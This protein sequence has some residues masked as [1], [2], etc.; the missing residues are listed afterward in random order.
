MHR[1]G[2]PLYGYWAYP[3]SYDDANG[4]GLL[5]LSEVQLGDTLEFQGS[6]HPSRQ[7]TAAT[8]IELLNGRL[9][10]SSLF[11]YRG[12]HAAGMQTEASRCGPLGTCR[13]ANDLSASL[14]EQAWA[15]ST[16]KQIG[17]RT[18][19]DDPAFTRWREMSVSYDLPQAVAAWVSASGLSLTLTGRN[20]WLWTD[21]HGFDPEL[22]SQPGRNE[23]VSDNLGVPQSR[24]W[25]L[26]VDARF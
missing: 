22:V 6:T 13:W 21:Y 24:Y 19:V 4:D 3:I 15:A 8:Q 5:S 11:D 20:L 17:F 26:R 16:K 14:Q 1:E 10:L 7:L 12:G 2:Y 23:G 25:L 18:L 9:R